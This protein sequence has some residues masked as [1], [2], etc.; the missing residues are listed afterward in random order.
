MFHWLYIE[1][2][3][4]MW[5]NIFAPSFFTLLGVLLSHI[6]MHRH[7][8]N[9]H[10]ELRAHVNDLMD[11]NTPGGLGEIVKDQNGQTS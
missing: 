3:Q 10:A 1:A 2:W 8:S 6:K 9:K 11:P 5:P 4:P 7:V